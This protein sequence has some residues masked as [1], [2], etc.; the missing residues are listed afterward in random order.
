MIRV[1]FN[2]NRV[3]NEKSIKEMSVDFSR[4]PLSHGDKIELL[5]SLCEA[6]TEVKDAYDAEV[7][8]ASSEDRL[9]NFKDVIDENFIWRKTGG[10][11]TLA[12]ERV[13]NVA[14]TA[15]VQKTVTPVKSPIISKKTIASVKK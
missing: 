7:A 15:P 3:E 5:N 2:I 12:T 13:I 11:T 14:G 1:E 10:I 4:T 6:L 9:P 8:A